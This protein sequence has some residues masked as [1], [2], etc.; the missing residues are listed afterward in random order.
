MAPPAD[1]KDGTDVLVVSDRSRFSGALANEEFKIGSYEVKDV[2]RKANSTESM[3]I[4]P[5]S[6]ETKTT[7]F[8]FALMSQSKRLAGKCESEQT[9]QGVSGF[10]WGDLKIVCLCEGGSGKAQ[11]QMTGDGRSLTLGD[12][13]YRVSPIHAIEG[14]KTQSEPSGFRADGE[15]LLGAV[16]VNHPGQV[17]LKKDLDDAVKRDATCVFVGL[18]MYQPPRNDK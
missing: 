9:L 1:V 15:G 8:T 18:M 14:G 3:G 16:E 7:G 6:K 12:Q 13:V 5:W 2:D 17:W 11:L 4:G 10:S